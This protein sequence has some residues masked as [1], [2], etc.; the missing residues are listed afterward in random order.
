VLLVPAL[1][2]VLVSTGLTGCSTTRAIHQ[3]DEEVYDLVNRISPRVKN[4]EPDFTID[5]REVTLDGIPQLAPDDVD[6]YLGEFSEAEAGAYIISLEKALELAVRNSRQYQSLKEGFYNQVLDFTLTRQEYRPV[7]SGGQINGT[8]NV[9]AVD[10]ADGNGGTAKTAEAPLSLEQAYAAVLSD[11][12]APKGATGS[13]SHIE[14]ERSVSGNTGLNLNMLTRGGTA[15]ALGLTTSFFRFLT[16]DPELSTPTSLVADISKPL[17]GSNRRT[18][19]ESIF[20]AERNLLYSFRDY[21]RDRKRFSIDLA[22][23]YYSLLQSRDRIRNN[24]E[25]YN[26]LQQTLKRDKAEAKYGLKTQTQVGLS[27]QAVLRSKNSWVNA[28]QDYQDSM[29]RFKLR[30]GLTM[31]TK[32]ILD[33]LELQKLVDRGLLVPPSLTLDEATELAFASRL[34]YFTR[35]EQL[36]DAARRL[37]IAGETLK[38][39]ITL[40]WSGR[41]GSR[42]GERFPD[43]D[44]KRYAWD[45]ALSVD[46]KLNRKGIRNAYRRQVISYDQSKRG[47]E[48]FKDELRLNLRRQYRGLESLRF[49]YEINLESLRL[50]ERRLFELELRRKIGE[51]RARDEVDARN[52]RIAASNAV[53]A[54]LVDHTIANLNLWL[55]MGILFIKNDGQWKDISYEEAS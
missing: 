37:E 34:D 44:F 53:S 12:A 13:G 8:L 42:A 40:A 49:Q 25:G 26:S 24:W 3:A 4:M 41:V 47:L 31:D 39:N 19:R 28:V 27:E 20:Q 33:S 29:D 1:L 52:D 51:V 45:L 9:A 22:S 43:L 55:D 7:V 17:W 15:I 2:L 10:V 23:T 14:Q 5:P 50:S 18:A 11:A 16:G 46:P 48:E 38:P 6:S 36:D 54:T 35:V 21:T 32:I 30:L